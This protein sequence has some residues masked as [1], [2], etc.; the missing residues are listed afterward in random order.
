MRGRYLVLFIAAS[1]TRFALTPFFGHSWDMY[2]WLQSGDLAVRGVNIYTL[3]ELTDFPWG[4]YSYPPLWLYW[5]TIAHYI[6]GDLALQVAIIKMPIVISDIISAW[7]L[8]KLAMYYGLGKDRSAVLSLIFFLNPLP[9]L[10]SSVWGMFDSIA[11]SFTLAAFYLL[12]QRKIEHSG[13]LLGLGAA[14]KIFPFFLVIPFTVYLRMFIRLGWLRII[15]F[16]GSVLLGLALPALPYLASLRGLVEKLSFHL[17]NVG[18]FT[19]W[20][21]VS[22]FLHPSIIGPLSFIAFFILVFFTLRKTLRENL[23]NGRSLLL[24]S[25]G[26]LI[27]FLAT[28]TKVN[29]QYTLWIL[30]FTI[31]LLSIMKNR[32]MAVNLVIVNILGVIFIL[33]GQV[34]LA[35]FDLRNLGRITPQSENILTSLAGLVILAAG[36]AAGTRFV[37]LLMNLLK[38]RPTSFWNPSRVA[39][40]GLVVMLA[41]SLSI[42]PSPKGVQLPYVSVRVG[43][44]EGVESF[45]TLEGD[46][47]VGLFRSKFDVTHVV[48]PVSPDLINRPEEMDLS[49]NSRFRLSTTPWTKQ[50]VERLL[51]GLHGIGVKSLLGIYLKSYYYSIHFGYHGY[52]STWLTAEHRS[53]TDEGGNIYFQY[54]IPGSNVTYADYFAYNAIKLVRDLGFDGLYIMG[55]DWSMGGDVVESVKSLLRSLNHHGGNYQIFLELDPYF[56]RESSSLA[57]FYDYADY[58]VVKTDPWVRRVKHNPIGNYTVPEFKSLLEEAVIS[59]SN[60]RAKI[61]F[62]VYA[63]DIVEGWLTP[64]VDLQVQ[65][66]QYSAVL[67]VEGYAIYNTNRYLPYRIKV[68]RPSAAY[69]S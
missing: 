35:L 31:L 57:E 4:F 51:H 32:E 68:E 65:V 14:A 47:G 64:A 3:R 22:N 42:F 29:V 9:I 39:V 34:S 63:I 44:M 1:V 61:L 54:M 40:I 5:L 55:V 37:A 16:I 27:A 30:P 25:S 8:Y 66:E 18:Q 53:L 13:F 59:S 21:A 48:I 11:V 56:L 38:L 62:G 58:I 60:H 41:V 69:S 26:V 36:V 12:L 24:S 43:M 19:Y 33:A 50:D 52:N 2:V 49:R 28:S 20:V 67:G 10:I 45:F 17:T 23:D 46:M 6:G 15:R 7:L